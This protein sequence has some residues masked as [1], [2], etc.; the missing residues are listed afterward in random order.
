MG[1]RYWSMI[2]DDGTEKWIFESRNTE[3]KVNRVDYFFFWG[4][5]VIAALVWGLFG[6][7][8]VMQFNFIWVKISKGIVI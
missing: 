2:L 7:L 3:S 4:S 1:L 6:A 8:N 5:M